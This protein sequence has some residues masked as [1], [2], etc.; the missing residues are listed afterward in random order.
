MKRL[1]IPTLTVILAIGAASPAGATTIGSKCVSNGSGPITVF[2]TGGALADS[3]KVPFDGILTR[4]GTDRT[5]TSNEGKLRA[6]IARYVGSDMKIISVSERGYAWPNSIGEFNA[7][8]PVV[9]GDR[10][11]ITAF[12]SEPRM[13]ST[14]NLSDSVS[15]TGNV[16]VG[17]T[18]T[19]S[20][21]PGQ[22]APVWAEIEVDADGDGY[23]DET[24][25]KCPQSAATI[26]PCP[27]LSISQQLTAAKGVINILAASN[28]DSS[29]TATAT[30]KLPKTK[31]SKAK[32]VTINGKP[33][34]FTGGKLKTIKLKLPSSV[35][36]L[37]KKTRKQ[38]P[39]KLTATVT[40]TGSGLANTAT[41]TAKVKL[42]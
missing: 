14:S 26:D 5:T 37:L 23:G 38:K 20:G 35:K 36:T 2:T 11:G 18:F 28:L 31:K 17:D 33:T 41:A 40:L 8:I 10:L 13:C 16:T 12:D 4:W 29:L 34:A 32:T 27:T 6:L 42:K 3:Y 19:P 22:I 25:D 24:Q 7:R 39:A 9:A 15:T 1:L 21:I 30:V